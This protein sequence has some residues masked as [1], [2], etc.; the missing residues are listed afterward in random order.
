MFALCT[1]YTNC[2]AAQ[3]AFFKFYWWLSNVSNMCSLV[4]N[5]LPPPSWLTRKDSELEESFNGDH[6][7][8][9]R[10]IMASGMVLE[11]PTD[12]TE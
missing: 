1:A 3:M 12:Q 8:L 6:A 11:Q 10:C 2:Q 5:G 7:I 4:C 9:K